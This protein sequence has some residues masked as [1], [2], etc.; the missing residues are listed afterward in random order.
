AEPRHRNRRRPT[1]PCRRALRRQARL[2]NRLRRRARRAEGRRAGL[3][4]AGNAGARGLR[5]RPSARRAQPA[6]PRH[7]G[8]GARGLAVRHA[9]RGL[10]RRSA[11][12][13]RRPGGAAPRAARSAG[14]DH[15]GRDGGLGGGGLPRGHGRGAGVVG[16]V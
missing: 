6:A 7:D 2:R 5:A 8:G 11:L 12:Q 9:V 15:A 10:L 16:G 1:R 13:R 4:A 14:E 3:R